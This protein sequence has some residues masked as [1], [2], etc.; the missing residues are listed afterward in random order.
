MSRSRWWTAAAKTRTSAS[1]PPG[2][3][4]GTSSSRSRSKPPNA[5]NRMAR[6]EVSTLDPARA[7]LSRDEASEPGPD[8]DLLLRVESVDGLPSQDRTDDAPL[9][10]PTLE[11]TPLVCVE[12]IISPYLPAAFWIQEDEVGLGTDADGFL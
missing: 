4:V 9:Q 3:L 2:L 1:S 10:G 8:E 6:C 12:E 5:W 11:G 7:F